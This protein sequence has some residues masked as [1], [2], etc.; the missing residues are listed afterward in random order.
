MNTKTVLDPV[1]E[2]N[3]YKF[4][5]LTLKILIDRI[6]V[7]ASCMYINLQEIKQLSYFLYQT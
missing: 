1:L 5:K 2:K 7:K 6:A 3:T 4:N